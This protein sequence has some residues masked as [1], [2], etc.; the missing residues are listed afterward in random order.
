MKHLLKI[1]VAL[2]IIII[3]YTILKKNKIIEEYVGHGWGLNGWRGH[4]G[5]GIHG[6]RG[7][8]GWGLG[9]R[10]RRIKYNTLYYKPIDNLCYDSLGNLTYCLTPN[11]IRPY[12][13]Y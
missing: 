7:H 3:L 2:L 4:N 13:Y 11:L 10:E 1:F 12:F 5:W 6:W 8:N 9:R